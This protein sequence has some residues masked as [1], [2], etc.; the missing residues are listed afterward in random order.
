MSSKTNGKK[1]RKFYYIDTSFRQ[2][3]D[4][5]IGPMTPEVTGIPV[6]TSI[7]GGLKAG[8]QHLPIRGRPGV[9]FFPQSFDVFKRLLVSEK[10]TP[11][12]AHLKKF[13][14]E[15]HEWSSLLIE[16]MSL[17]ATVPGGQQPDWKPISI[18]HREPKTAEIE[19]H[20]RIYSE[21]S[22][23]VYELRQLLWEP[24]PCEHGYIE[25]IGDFIND[26]ELNRLLLGLLSK[27]T[28]CRWP[29][30]EYRCLYEKG[31][32]L[33]AD[34]MRRAEA[35]S[36]YKREKPPNE[37]TAEKGRQKSECDSAPASSAGTDWKYVKE[38]FKPNPNWHEHKRHH[39]DNKSRSPKEIPATFAP[40]NISLP[41]IPQM[42]KGSKHYRFL[43]EA[44]FQMACISDRFGRNLDHI[45]ERKTG[46][47]SGF[48]LPT[49]HWKVIVFI[50]TGGIELADSTVN[51]VVKEANKASIKYLQSCQ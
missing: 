39:E 15:A 5:F 47:K 3:Y 33:A 10:M 23:K 12:W 24:E 50:G 46:V 38:A 4:S 17:P 48:W 41:G 6:L 9:G 26:S 40:P 22:E 31:S 44:V 35:Y 43:R 36:V 20:K 51:K 8:L 49:K 18:H 30:L 16:V 34:E 42:D 11:A 14:P 45:T 19:N 1:S 21:I 25:S 32:T 28:S 13:F 2:P 27:T 29:E 37:K 7:P